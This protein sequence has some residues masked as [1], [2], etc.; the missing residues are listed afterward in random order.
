MKT[1]RPSSL[2]LALTLGLV[3][4][5]FGIARADSNFSVNDIEDV[6]DDVAPNEP[7]KE[8]V[9]VVIL[10]DG[11]TADMKPDFLA[12]ARDIVQ[13]LRSGKTAAPMRE[14]NTFSFHEVWVPS[15]A[16]GAPWRNGEDPA[17]TPFQTHVEKDGTLTSDDAAV[18]RAVR[19]L[20]PQAKIVIPVV[21][22]RLKTKAADKKSHA[23][24]GIDDANGDPKDVRDISNTPEDLFKR[25]AS[26]GTPESHVAGRVHQVDDDMRAFVHEFGHAAYGLDD[27]YSNNST[28]HIPDEGI[29][30]VAEFPNCTTDPTGARWRAIVP[31]LYDAQG[32][33]RQIFEGGSGFAKG[34]WHAFKLC[35]M[36]QSRTED[37]CP[38]CQA[39]I[40]GSRHRDVPLPA[41]SLTSPTDQES[42]ASTEGAKGRRLVRADWKPAAGEQPN[43]YHLE[44]RDPDGRLR[45]ETD[46]E[47]HLTTAQVPVPREGSYSLTIEARRVDAANAA[48]R[49]PG[50]TVG[51]SVP[52]DGG[53]RSGIDDVLSDRLRREEQ[54]HAD[55]R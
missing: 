20:K 43:S 24:S 51:F 3:A 45:Y 53:P 8:P 11:Y 14:V 15:K 54:A 13:E 40:R 47:G 7:G 49:S 23:P 38:V 36:N 35:R 32:K 52:A 21:L 17:D 22:I 29:A 30:G 26:G 46:V 27:E 16:K 50:V 9:E 1:P 39:A 41:P 31:E 42:V 44:V 18:D 19:H 37:F 28:D 48:A 55:G 12:K 6:R 10:S 2:A 5:P 25:I 33:I 34:V 4:T